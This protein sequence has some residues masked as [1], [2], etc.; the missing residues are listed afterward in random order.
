[1][2]FEVGVKHTVGVTNAEGSFYFMKSL[3]LI[4]VIFIFFFYFFFQYEQTKRFFSPSP[5]ITT[6]IVIQRSI[7][8]AKKYKRNL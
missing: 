2:D 6:G 7:N 1:M 8:N 3:E 4:Q 5:T